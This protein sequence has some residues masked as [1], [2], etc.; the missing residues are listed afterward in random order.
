MFCYFAY[1]L[2]EILTSHTP[3]MLFWRVF[4]VQKYRYADFCAFTVTNTR[5]I[6][7]ICVIFLSLFCSPLYTI[8]YL[9]RGKSIQNAFVAYS[10]FSIIHLFGEIT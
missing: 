8:D 9:V 4:Y 10:C 6:C 1:K 7:E 5:D 3:K 2:N